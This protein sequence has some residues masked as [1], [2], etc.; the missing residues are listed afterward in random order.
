MKEKVSRAKESVRTE[1]NKK[2]TLSN[3]RS[4]K[5]HHNQRLVETYTLKLEKEK[6]NLPQK[7]I[8]NF[9]GTESIE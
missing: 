1:W 8:S 2:Y 3:E 5:F 9:N 7:F 6:P 4:W